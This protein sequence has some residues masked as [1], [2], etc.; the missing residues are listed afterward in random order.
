MIKDN[1]NHSSSHSN[2]LWRLT[3]TAITVFVT[4][5]G[6]FAPLAVS[7]TALAEKAAAPLAVAAPSN[8]L[9]LSVVSAAD[10]TTSVGGFKYIINIDNTGT[11]EQRSP[12]DGCSPSSPGYPDSCN[13][14]SIAGVKSSAPIF[15]QGDQSDF[16]AGFDLPAGRYLVSVLADGFKIDGAH[17]T[18]PIV[19]TDNDP[20]NANVTVQMQPYDLPDATIQAEVFEDNAPTNSAPDVPAERGIAG[21]K[22]HI[23]DYIDEVT[24]D[25]Y[26]DPL[27]GDQQ[28]V[29]KCYAVDGGIDIGIVA[30]TFADGRCP[31]R[32]EL[33]ANAMTL[34]DF[35][36]PGDPSVAIGE[37][38]IIQGKVIIPNLGPN[39]Y[40]LSV[41]PPNN[42][43]WVQTTTLEGNHDWDAWVME[44]ATGLDTEFVVA[45]EPFPATFFGYVKATNTMGTGSG[46]IKGTALAVSA[47]IPPVGGIGGEAGLLGAKPKDKNPIH[48]LFVSLSD[49]NNNDLTVYMHEFDCVEP[50]CAPVNFDIKNV[51]DGDYVLGVWD[52]PQDYIFLE[53]NVSIVNGETA[54][55][56][57]LSMVLQRSGR[58]RSG[59]DAHTRELHHGPWCD[60]RE[61][62]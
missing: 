4:T 45:G 50:A 15:T 16:G 18:V 59:S 24:T 36:N 5:I 58:A 17:F 55:L 61:Y 52:E 49:I 48:R 3:V 38:A 14:V 27:C 40:A 42:S 8:T 9:R 21:F 26:G 6:S 29:S 43:P 11:T 37:D 51:P 60:R 53:Q 20:S 2:V 56:G 23:A 46:E 31:F 57:G 32:D 44:G 25:V 35:P 22:A 34:P 19:D 1:P 7:A 39:R 54:D 33:P 41:V 12:S 13:W 30:P 47:Y 10:G 28:C 62:G